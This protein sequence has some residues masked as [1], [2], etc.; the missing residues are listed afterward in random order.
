VSHSESCLKK[1]IRLSFFSDRGFP[2]VTRQHPGRIGQHQ[3]TMM[4]RAQNLTSIPTGQIGPPDGPGEQGIAGKQQVLF[5]KEQADAARRVPRGMQH[6]GPE[7]GKTERLAIV[8]ATVRRCHLGRLDT[9]PTGLHLHHAQQLQVLLV[10]IHRRPGCLSKLGG[11]A[12]MVDMC[13]GHDNL[14]QGEAVLPEP[15]ENFRDVVSR[16]DDHG[17]V[18]SLVAQDGAIAAQRTDGKGLK[19]HSLILEASFQWAGCRRLT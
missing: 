2:S 10:E 17:F 9:E 18:G 5:R 7:A 16:V 3:Q 6:L 15:G 4:Q 13:M 19:D 12:Y 1:R 8:R 14:A 11:S